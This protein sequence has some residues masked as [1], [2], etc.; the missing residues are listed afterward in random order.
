[1]KH[2]HPIGSGPRCQGG[3]PQPVLRRPFTGRLPVEDGLSTLQRGGGQVDGSVIR[4]GA[5]TVLPGVE[6]TRQLILH[7]VELCDPLVD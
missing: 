7:G 1:M 2:R 6:Q 3:E 5:S 4:P